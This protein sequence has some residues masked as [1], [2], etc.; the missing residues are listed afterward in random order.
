MRTAVCLFPLVAILS[1]TACEDSAATKKSSAPSTDD[2]GSETDSGKKTTTKKDAGGSTADA[3]EETVDC[4]AFAAPVS[5]GTLNRTYTGEA[6]GLAASRAHP[7][8]LWTHNDSNNPNKVYAIS[9]T[10]GH[11]LAEYTVS[12]GSNDDWEDIAI[13]Y[14][15]NELYLADIGDNPAFDGKTGRTSIALYRFAE[16][17]IE[18]TAATD[19]GAFKTGTVSATKIVM[20][21]PDGARNAESFGIDS[22]KH[23]GYVFSKMKDGTSTAYKLDLGAT[24]PVVLTKLATRT[25]LSKTDGGIATGA[26][27]GESGILLRTYSG[28]YLFPRLQGDTV[29]DMWNRTPCSLDAP[30]ITQEPQGEAIAWSADE[31]GFFTTT[32]SPSEFIS[33]PLDYSAKK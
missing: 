9:A 31:K 11:L 32:E 23:E 29:A 2:D 20:T 10:D 26:D 17:S 13:D 15:K 28:V 27:I 21:Y 12:G 22:A 18:D 7:G 1:F 25:F 3:G 16:P 30:K 33:Q 6:S 14:E 24:S 19:G 5:R 4:P 8:V